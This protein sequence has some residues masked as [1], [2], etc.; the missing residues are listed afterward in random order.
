MPSGCTTELSYRGQQFLT[1]IFERYDKD[2]DKA[3][4]P[5]E[6]EELFSTC[7]TPAWPPDVSAMVQTNEKGNFEILY[8]I[9][10][11]YYNFY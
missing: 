6:Y 2:R 8:C 4:S 9:L 1:N 7:P 5:F 10:N 3:L 11:I